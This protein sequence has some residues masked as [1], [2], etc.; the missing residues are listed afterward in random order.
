MNTL[1]KTLAG[2]ALASL[3]SCTLVFDGSQPPAADPVPSRTIRLAENSDGG[4]N[5]CSFTVKTESVW[6]NK[7]DHSCKNDEMSYIKLDNVRSAVL[8]QLRSNDCNEDKGWT[9]TLRTYIEPIT[10]LWISIDQLRGQ[11]A[12]TIVAKGVLLVEGYS[13]DENI[14]GKLSCVNV[15][16]ST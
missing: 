4:G 7:E 11:P 5:N 1:I 8:I 9:F 16:E 10:T 13:G 12:N 2:L 6:L 3:A 14:T 15:A